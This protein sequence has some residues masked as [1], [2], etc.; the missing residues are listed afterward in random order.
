M[1]LISTVN[2]RTAGLLLRTSRVHVVT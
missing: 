1:F 2:C